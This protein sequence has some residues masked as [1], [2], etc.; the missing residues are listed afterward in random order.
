MHASTSRSDDYYSGGCLK[1]D[2]ALIQMKSLT[3]AR[4]TYSTI[5]FEI[6]VSPKFKWLHDT[7]PDFYLVYMVLHTKD[8]IS[9]E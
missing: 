5:R 8:I 1:H 9:M 6:I 3:M 2:G 4:Q 7:M